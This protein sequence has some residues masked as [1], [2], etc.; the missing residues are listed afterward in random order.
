MDEM[1]V[2]IF[3]GF[4]AIVLAFLIYNAL[5]CKHEWE[6]HGVRVWDKRRKHTV[7]AYCLICKKCGKVKVLK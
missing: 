7:D 6:E 3:I 1:F 4:T 5:R 2:W